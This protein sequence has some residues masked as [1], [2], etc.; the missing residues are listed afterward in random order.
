MIKFE[1]PLKWDKFVHLWQRSDQVVV[2]GPGPSLSAEQITMLRGS[3]AITIAVGDAGRVMMPDADIMY[4]C[5]RKYWIHYK[6][7]PDFQGVRVSLEDTQFEDIF[8]VKESEQKEG[9]VTT[10]PEIVI[11]N[12]SG[13]QAISLAAH[14]RPKEIILIGYDMKHK[15]GQENCIGKHPDEI[16]RRHDFPLFIG[17]IQKLV[18]PLY[19]L[20]ISVYNCTI[21]SDLNCFPKKGLT[22]VLGTKS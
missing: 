12:N 14:F 2:I 13:Y 3:D 10:F 18:K 7:C 17:S 5:D 4:H 8:Q 11:G 20:G 6:G 1:N 15:G 21:D 19:D 22:D 16:R 9:L